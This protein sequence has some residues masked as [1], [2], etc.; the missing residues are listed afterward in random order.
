VLTFKGIMKTEI[1][2]SSSVVLKL[3]RYLMDG[4]GWVVNL[5]VETT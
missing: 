3:G 1:V 4:A 5:P 2:H